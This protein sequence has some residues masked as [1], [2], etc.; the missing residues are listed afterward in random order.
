MKLAVFLSFAVFSQVNC[1]EIS[2]SDSFENGRVAENSTRGKGKHFKNLELLRRH[3]AYIATN[4][5]D[6]PARGIQP[7]K[8]ITRTNARIINMQDFF[9]KCEIRTK[10]VNDR[11]QARKDAKAAEEFHMDSG[12]I[13]SRRAFA[14]TPEDAKIA[15]SDMVNSEENPFQGW[16][17]Q[18]TELFPC[19][20]SKKEQPNILNKYVHYFTRVINTMMLRRFEKCE[21]LQKKEILEATINELD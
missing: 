2:D 9:V 17:D 21:K 11:V 15:L 16:I 13:R 20:Q 5:L 19:E 6:C 8:I 1:Q 3:I 4:Y 12:E 14:Q 18:F 10:L 7:E